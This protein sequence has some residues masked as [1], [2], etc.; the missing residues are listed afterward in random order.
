[1]TLTNGA[2]TPSTT[3]KATATVK[4]PSNANTVYVPWML[5]TVTV[6]KTW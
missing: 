5:G 6:K 1:M 4:K 2:K 3:T